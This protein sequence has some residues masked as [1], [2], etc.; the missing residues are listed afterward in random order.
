MEVVEEQACEQQLHLAAS[1]GEPTSRKECIS[2]QYR[3]H[4]DDALMSATDTLMSGADAADV[5][6]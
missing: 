1:S 5:W 4:A 6:S 3:M 2:A